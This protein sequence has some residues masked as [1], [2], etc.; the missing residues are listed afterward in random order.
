[1]NS[2]TRTG[3]RPSPRLRLGTPAAI[4]FFVFSLVPGSINAQPATSSIKLFDAALTAG[5]GPGTSAAQALPYATRSIVLVKSAGDTAV[6]SSTP[7]GTGNIVIDNFI[8]INGKNACEGAVGRLY[9][10]SCFGPVLDT[11]L[12]VNVPVETS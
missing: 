12:P 8:T 4:G 2:Q 1:M 3:S 11:T 7:D 9:F 10:D 6:L 5:T